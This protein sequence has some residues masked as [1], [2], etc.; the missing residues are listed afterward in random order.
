MVL[1]RE[2]VWREN[3]G[4]RERERLFREPSRVFTHSFQ[5][6]YLLRKHLLCMRFT[7]RLSYHILHLE[8]LNTQ[9]VLCCGESKQAFRI[10][11]K[12]TSYYA[13]TY[14][15][16]FL[17]IRCTQQRFSYKYHIVGEPKLRVQLGR[18]AEH[19]VVQRCAVRHLVPAANNHCCHRD[20]WMDGC[21]DR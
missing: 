15:T 21:M 4:F 1:E 18:L 2:V 9:Q 7:E 10:T 13:Y 5:S 19:H 12:C 6:R 20:G 17:A 14:Y 8:V 16:Y 11:H 3:S